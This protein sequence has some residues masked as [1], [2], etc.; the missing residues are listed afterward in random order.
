MNV[1]K[2]LY[3][4]TLVSLLILAGCLGGGVIDEG[5]GQS[6]PEDNGTTVIN[7]Y[8]NA[9]YVNATYV[10]E[11]YEVTNYTLTGTVQPPI[12]Y[13][14]SYVTCSNSGSISDVDITCIAENM[15]AIDIDGNIT[16]FGFD[17]N[18]DMII[19]LEILA[20]QGMP[21]TILNIEG[22]QSL[23]NLTWFSNGEQ[24]QRK[25]MMTWY[26]IAIDNSGESTVEL[27]FPYVNHYQIPVDFC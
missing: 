15:A 18:Q 24:E 8:V 6:V 23:E 3:V 22:N 2:G 13:Q 1:L 4:W 20:N 5:E 9:T 11:T 17:V 16:E 27:Y 26:L 25:C 19:D 7:E 21:Q 10:N 14:H 12:I